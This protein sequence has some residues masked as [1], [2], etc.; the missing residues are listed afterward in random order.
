MSTSIRAFEEQDIDR[1]VELSLAAWRPV[2][3]S[4][5][6]LLGDPLYFR[7]FPDWRESQRR[8]VRS[9]CSSEETDIWVAIGDGGPVGFV[10]SRID[11]A[12]DPLV[13]EIEMI[14][15][16]PEHQRSGIATELLEHAVERLDAAGV[17]L[18]ALATGGDPGHTPARGL[19]EKAGFTALPLVRYY[20]R[21]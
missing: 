8:A 5:R 10:A 1:V 2:F 13:G 16:D 19:Y 12:S 17:D 4:F 21:P 18:V 9:V 20:R 6:R 15:V 3:E 14:A 11:L 7:A